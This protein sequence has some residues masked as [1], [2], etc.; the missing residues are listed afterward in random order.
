VSIHWSLVDNVHKKSGLGQLYGTVKEASEEA[1]KKCPPSRKD[2]AM[3]VP[4]AASAKRASMLV[5]MLFALCAIFALCQ[6]AALAAPVRRHAIVAR[7]TIVLVHGAWADASGWNDEITQMQRY[8]YTVVA[9]PNPLRGVSYDA[10]V[11]RNF[12]KTI[13][14]PIILVGHSYGGFVITNAATGN[15][16][17]KALVY[18]D[19][20]IPNQG[21]TV[22]QLVSARPGTCLSGGG[23]P[24]KVFTFVTVP[25]APA[26]DYD[27]YL[28]TQADA[29]Y[30]GGAQCFA[31]DLPAYR[32]AQVIATQRP[33]ALKANTEPSGAPAWKSIPSWALIGTADHVIP[34]AELRFMAQRAHAHTVSIYASHVSLISHPQAVTNLI[35]SAVQATI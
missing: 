12:L 24:T 8:G 25:G 21:E 34:P 18:I 7:P 13:K 6:S 17:V 10:G 31:N 35:L 27:A 20:F 15:S 26:G 14:G 11:L 1:L 23:D 19:A 4:S 3:F 9:P 33:I 29:P 22:N 2:C 32:A 30:P 16:N 5:A 28:K